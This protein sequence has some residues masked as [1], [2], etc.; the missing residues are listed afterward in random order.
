MR[1]NYLLIVFIF[2]VCAC[3]C[4]TVE[5]S[6]GVEWNTIQLEFES[7]YAIEK[8]NNQKLNY[9]SLPSLLV[10]YGLLSKVEFQFNLPVVRERLFVNN[11]L[12]EESNDFGD[13]Q[14]GMSVDL[15]K[16]KRILPEAALMV[17]AI[18][19]VGN[20]R[21]TMAAGTIISLNLMNRLGNQFFIGYNLGL[22]R[23]PDGFSSGFYILNLTYEFSQKFHLFMEQ[24]G[25]FTFDDF[26]SHNLNIGFGGTLCKNVALDISLG[27]G[28]SAKMNYVG[29]I[30]TWVLKS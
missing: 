30:L 1:T 13:M 9:W 7:Q 25:D 23:Q 10:R 18:V 21:D 24:F 4:Q 8:E 6:S 15:W 2:I 12:V 28:L 19:P 26:L 29:M 20:A 22:V 3:Y 16:Q 27:K 5:P 14:I 17:R 11:K